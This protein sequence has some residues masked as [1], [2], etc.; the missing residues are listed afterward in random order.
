MM[1]T[2][3]FNGAT[4][5]TNEAG[6]YFYKSTNSVD[7]KGNPLFMRISEKVFEEAWEQSGEA[8]KAKREALQAKSDAEAEKAVKKPRKS[9]DI[10]FE[11]DTI[12]GHITLTAKQVKFLKM[13]PQDDF[14]ENGLESTLWIDVFCDTVAG[15]FN[16]MAVGAMVS[17]LNEKKV[18]AVSVERVN[19]KKCKYMA[20]TI[21]GQ[22]IAEK[23]GLK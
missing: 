8:E 5:K 1:R 16:P 20:L 18:L 4:Y 2:F 23:L 17:T 21:V 14:W 13:M 22:V 12:E 7:K 11:I 6:N 9:K 3:E 15:E 19:G 10:A